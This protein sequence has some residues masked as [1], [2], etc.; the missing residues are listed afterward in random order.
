L[1]CYGRKTGKAFLINVGE[2][3]ACRKTIAWIVESMHK[4]AFEMLDASLSGRGGSAAL[5]FQ[6]TGS[7]FAGYAANPS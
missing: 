7:L 5:S 3:P 6:R 2:F 4:D 1:Q